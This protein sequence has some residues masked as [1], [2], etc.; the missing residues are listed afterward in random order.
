MKRLFAALSTLSLAACS[1]INAPEDVKPGPGEQGCAKASDCPKSTD[2]C[3][4]AACTNGVCTTAPANEGNTCDDGKFCTEMDTCSG[5]VCGGQPKACV[6][7]AAA[8]CS[9]DVCDEAQQKCVPKPAND[10]ADCDD[11]NP[12]DDP[13][14]CAAGACSKGPDKCAKLATDCMSASCVAGQ[15]CMTSPTNEGAACDTKNTCATSVCAAGQCVGTPIMA[16]ESTPCDDGKFCTIDETCKAGKCT[17]SNHSMCPPNEGCGAWTCD[18]AT[19]TCVV[20]AKNEGMSCTFGSCEM[21]QTCA[22]GI[23]TGP[24]SATIYFFDD[25]SQGN[26][27]GW[28]TPPPAGPCPEFGAP[29]LNDWMF[30][31]AVRS[32]GGTP[33][34]NMNPF[35]TDP[36]ED[37]SPNTFENGIAG[38]NLGQPDTNNQTPGAG[39]GN[40][41]RYIHDPYYLVTPVINTNGAGPLTLSFYRWLDSDYPPFMND[42]VEVTADG[43][44]WQTL[45]ANQSM[46]LINDSK[47]SFQTLDITAYRSPNMQVRWGYSVTQT[48]VYS[49]GSWNI[50]DVLIAD[51]SCP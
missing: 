16:S 27:K 35:F 46:I 6:G 41:D 18:E 12:C 32:S 43:F 33:F 51:T 19:K 44:N 45:F 24:T 1:L 39:K 30:G 50:D 31:P 22:A 8:A 3:R 15:G 4:E 11:G 10:G 9:M 21:N 13:G 7:G 23:C 26:V 38:V 5:G 47:W 37:H 14:K 42:T 40:A 28:A 36:E 17:P 20:D 25:F 49:V 29:C 48:G 2:A 34:D